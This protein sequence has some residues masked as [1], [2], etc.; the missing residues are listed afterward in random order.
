MKLAHYSDGSR[1]SGIDE[2]RLL[3]FFFLLQMR[4]G[5][6]TKVFLGVIGEA[7]PENPNLL[8]TIAYFLLDWEPLSSKDSAILS[9]SRAWLWHP[10][11]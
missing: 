3:L 11:C 10:L 7:S 1:V 4:K 6:L 9:V 2:M 5:S 8:G